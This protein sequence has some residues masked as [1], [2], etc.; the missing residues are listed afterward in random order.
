[1]T[2]R[3]K[4]SVLILCTAVFLFAVPV[5]ASTPTEAKDSVVCIAIRDSRGSMIG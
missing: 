4:V 3:L 1:M 2:K 5:M